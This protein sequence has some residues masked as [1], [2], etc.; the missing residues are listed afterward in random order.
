MASKVKLNKLVLRAIGRQRQDLYRSNTS[1]ALI[2]EF[3]LTTEDVVLA[4][5]QTKAAKVFAEPFN[6]FFVPFAFTDN[7]YI[8]F[9][10]FYL[11]LP[12]LTTIGGE[13]K[14]DAFDYPVQSCLSKSCTAKSSAL[15]AT[16]HKV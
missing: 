10:R 4:T 1:S 12:P 11:G 3:S 9:S 13:A 6:R 14:S 15:D 8:A 16:R 2:D 7:E 5:A